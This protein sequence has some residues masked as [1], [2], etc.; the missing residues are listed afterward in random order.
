MDA[1]ALDKGD[2]MDAHTE[3]AKELILAG[4]LKAFVPSVGKRNWSQVNFLIVHPKVSMDLIVSAKHVGLNGP[5]KNG[6]KRR[7]L[8]LR[9]PQKKLLLLSR[10]ARGK[11]RGR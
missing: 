2:P 1:K 10:I 7:M 8:G 11:G 5:K 6:W 9:N 3:Q 4:K